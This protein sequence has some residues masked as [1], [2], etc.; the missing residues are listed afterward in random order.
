MFVMDHSVYMY[1]MYIIKARHNCAIECCVFVRINL[2]TG[3][4]T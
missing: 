3:F 1:V 4:F 2:W